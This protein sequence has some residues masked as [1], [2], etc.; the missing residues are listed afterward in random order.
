MTVRVH[1]VI[2]SSRVQTRLISR[3]ASYSLGSCSSNTAINSSR[4]LLTPTAIVS[5]SHFAT[6]SRRHL[7]LCASLLSRSGFA[8]P[9]ECKTKARYFSMQP[10]P[11]CPKP[12]GGDNKSQLCEKIGFIG[13]GKIA[14]VRTQ[15]APFISRSTLRRS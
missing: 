3:S 7:S 1:Q 12:N 13:A 11:V 10:E 9:Y 5:R 8:N 14:Q 6:W 15:I 4:C 2:C